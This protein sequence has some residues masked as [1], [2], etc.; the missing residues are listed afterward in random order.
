MFYFQFMIIIVTRTVMR[1]SA[2][3]KNR[4]VNLPQRNLLIGMFFLTV[5]TT[6]ESFIQSSTSQ[7]SKR[8]L[9]RTHYFPTELGLMKVGFIEQIKCTLRQF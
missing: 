9:T 8:P 6:D 3:P 1:I 7:L 2:H 4:Q 5:C